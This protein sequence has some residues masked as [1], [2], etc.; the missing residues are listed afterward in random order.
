M[1]FTDII[2]RNGS[3]GN[4]NGNGNGHGNE[5]TG[6]AVKRE[7]EL[8]YRTPTMPS[9]FE[10]PNEWM[11]RWDRMFDSFFNRALGNWGGQTTWGSGN[12]S[13]NGMS[14]FTPA[15]N[16]AESDREYRVT[17]ELP[18]MDEQDIELSLHRD[19]LTIKGEKK[20]EH[21]EKGNGYHR[22]ERS[23]GTF[24]RTIPLPQE[25]DAERVEAN[26][27]KGVLTITLPKLPEVQSGAKRIAIKGEGR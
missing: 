20:Q 23:Y 4:G 12:I 18:G 11:R 19:H 26:F 27:Q 9:F 16:L 21:E 22:V 3:N 2:K 14:T 8:D 7:N 24:Q 17:A 13:F 1:A 15:I 5:N 6:L 25:V 10:D